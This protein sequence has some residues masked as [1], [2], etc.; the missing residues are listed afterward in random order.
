MVVRCF[1]PVSS[2]NKT[3]RHDITEIVFCESGVKH[4][5]TNKPTISQLYRSVS[6]ICGGNRSSRGKPAKCHKTLTNFIS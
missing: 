6:F 3:D 4:N 2:T 1:S 5:K